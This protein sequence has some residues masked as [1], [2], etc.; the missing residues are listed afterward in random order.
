MLVSGGLLDDVLA[1]RLADQHRPGLDA[2]LLPLETELGCPLAR[3][4]SAER[5]PEGIGR[6][7]RAIP[8][9]LDLR[10]I[11]AHNLPVVD[12]REN[13]PADGSSDQEHTRQRLAGVA[14]DLRDRPPVHQHLEVIVGVEGCG[15]RGGGGEGDGG[16]RIGRSGAGRSQNQRH[17][18]GRERRQEPSSEGAY[19]LD[20]RRQPRHDPPN[21]IHLVQPFSP[22]APVAGCSLFLIE[23][24]SDAS[25][26]TEGGLS[27]QTRSTRPPPTRKNLGS[28]RYRGLIE[29]AG[30][31][32]SSKSG[33][34]FQKNAPL[35]CSPA[36]AKATSFG[37][38]GCE[39]RALRAEVVSRMRSLLMSMRATM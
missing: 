31:S 23:E 37:I 27:F 17:G 3:L 35:S 26:E 18:G 2:D 34:W 25:S 1:G 5:R 12:P 32:R 29:A 11:H 21:Q 7:E 28:L 20:G 19:C 24:R 38:P 15:G 16:L 8:P 36:E 39:A 33:P 10:G 6:N 9:D 14:G 4:E 13:G 22:A 30:A